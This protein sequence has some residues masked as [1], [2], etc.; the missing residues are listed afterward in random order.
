MLKKKQFEYPLQL[1]TFDDYEYY[2]NQKSSHVAEEK[3]EE[4]LRIEDELWNSQSDNWAV[5]EDVRQPK[6]CR[7]CGHFIL[8]G[9]CEIDSCTCICEVTR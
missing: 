8:F 2:P 7:K 6:K 5:S 1:K 4:I 9:V 3:L